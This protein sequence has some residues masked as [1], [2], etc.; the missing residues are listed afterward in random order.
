MA[1]VDLNQ[2]AY[3]PINDQLHY[4][5]YKAHY[6]LN[7]LSDDKWMYLI[8]DRVSFSGKYERAIKLNKPS[9]DILFNWLEKIILGGQCSALFVEDLPIDDI[10]TTRIKGL[11]EQNLITLINLT[12][13]SS[14]PDNLVIGPWH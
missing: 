10:R 14:L 2:Q 4:Q 7:Q 13:D 8:S 12:L 11:C 9:H 5:N 1:Q 6:G 3:L